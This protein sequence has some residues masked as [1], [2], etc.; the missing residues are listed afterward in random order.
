[1]INVTKE[2]FQVGGNGLTSTEDAA[3][4][5]IQSAGRAALVDAGCGGSLNI[6]L[7]NIRSSG[8]KPSQIEYLL[9]T[10]CHYDH[11]G[12]AKA[13]RDKMKCRTVA[14]ELDAPFMENGDNTV[15]AANWYGG[16]LE[17]F[18][19]DRKLTGSGEEVRLG[20]QVIQAIHI[21][22]HSPGSL[23]YLMTSE[24]QRVLFGQDVH[25][26]LAP[27]L[28]SNA[29][30]YRRSLQHLLSLDVDILCEGHY[31]VLNGK[32]EVRRFIQSFLDRQDKN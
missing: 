8:V 11:I 18:P 31:G 21:P 6:L 22:G 12:G 16:T 3:I 10:H 15:T 24:D 30:D 5:L 23:A 20:D 29:V 28:L 13:I 4:Y 7:K 17:A 27:T 9:L 32:K 14:H 25:G 2:I 26:P 1:M 19:V